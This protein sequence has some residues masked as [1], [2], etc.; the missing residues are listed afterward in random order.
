MINPLHLRT[1]LVLAET[2]HFTQTAERLFMTQPGVSQHI[3]KLEAALNTSLLQRYG[4]QFELT[5]AGEKLRQYGLQREYEEEL[6][7][8][9]LNED[10]AYQGEC[11]LASS[12]AIATRIY[13]ELLVLQQ[14]HPMLSF[15]LEAAPNEGIIKRVQQNLCELGIV[16]RKSGDPE[17]SETKL[18][19]DTLCLVLPVGESHDWENLCRLGFINHPDGHHYATQVL[20]A[21]Y[22]DKFS[23]MGQFKQQGFINQLSQILLPV[24]RGLGFTVLPQSALVHNPLAVDI[25]KLSQ[26]VNETVYL[27]TK[28][29]RPL[30]KRYQLLN[31][32]LTGLWQ[33]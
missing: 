3:K 12:G 21:N 29:H 19:T 30:A 6:L 26:P 33:S 22:G 16:T 15:Q 5:E 18:G 4:K 23:Q 13:P 24:S 14:T 25:A 9:Q 2:G 10:D 1:F 7:L 27:I 32:K 17:M 31:E 11:R 20:A 28:K 8:S